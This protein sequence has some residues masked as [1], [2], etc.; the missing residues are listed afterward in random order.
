MAYVTVVNYSR[1]VIKSESREEFESI[2][3]NM[4]VKCVEKAPIKTP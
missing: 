2:P 1:L 3:T 4:G